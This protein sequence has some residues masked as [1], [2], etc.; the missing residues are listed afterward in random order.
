M[1]ISKLEELT[2]PQ[3]A[4]L[5]R[6]TTLILL[7]VSPVEEH[8]PHLPLGVDY[9]DAEHFCSR[10]AG[11]FAAEHPKWTVLLLPALVAGSHAFEAPG[12]VNVRARAV[13][14]L[15]YDYGAA[16]ARHGFRYFFL[17]NGHGAAGHLVVLEEAA[18]AVERRYGMKMVSLSSSIIPEMF[19]GAYW[20]HIEKRLGRALTV[21]ERRMLALDSHAGLLETSFML[22]LRPDLVSEN[23][24]ELRPFAPPRLERLKGN[25]AMRKGRQG[26]VGFPAAATAEFGAAAIEA[27]IDVAYKRMLQAM[28]NPRRERMS[29][30]SRLPFL[31][32][33]FQRY[34]GWAAAVG[35][36][37]TLGFLFGRKA[38]G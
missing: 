7:S 38:K 18:R 1:P 33:D 16:F 9:F 25:Y 28:R 6:A 29:A 37:L 23:F 36:A 35:A 27:M 5:D 32:T 19:S 3:V 20:G 12:T 4:A 34:A 24:R 13:R 8:G 26:Y 22:R 31:R 15:V 30:L 10:L 17:S 2:Y 21:E 14:D 11:C